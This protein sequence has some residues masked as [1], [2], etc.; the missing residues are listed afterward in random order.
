MD[1][2]PFVTDGR[3]RD[4]AAQL[5]DALPILRCA[6]HACVQAEAMRVGA[7]RRFAVGKRR[8]LSFIQPQH[9]APRAWALR[10][11]P[12]RCGRLQRIQHVIGV[13]V[14]QVH[15]A[16]LLDQM[17]CFAQQLQNSFDDFVEQGCSCV[18]VGGAASWNTG[19]PSP[20]SP[21]V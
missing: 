11:A 16:L 4:V 13:G 5:F 17:P 12:G 15:L 8:A 14:G 18:A 2:K 9:C 10:D 7:Q 20:A 3:A 19:S 1:A 21:V 6:A